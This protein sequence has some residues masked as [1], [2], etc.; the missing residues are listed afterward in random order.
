MNFSW[1]FGFSFLKVIISLSKRQK[2]QEYR[3]YR[4][5]YRWDYR[6]KDENPDENT[7]ENTDQKM[8]LL[9]STEIN[10]ILKDFTENY[11][12]SN[13]MVVNF[14]LVFTLA[15]I[16]TISFFCAFFANAV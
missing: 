3:W 2:L 10:P 6:S 16:L 9:N 12:I 1:F 7:D 15:T 11:T 8:K 5:E 4:W 14:Y 13:R